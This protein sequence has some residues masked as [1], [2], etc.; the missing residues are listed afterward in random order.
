MQL[1]GL[2]ALSNDNRHLILHTAQTVLV[3]ILLEEERPAR[4][5]PALWTVIAHVYTAASFRKA[6]VDDSYPEGLAAGGVGVTWTSSK[7]QLS[8]L[9][10]TE[11]L[12]TVLLCMPVA[13][14]VS[15]VITFT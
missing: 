7:V 14:D 3:A 4:G 2:I 6:L 12:A 1:I 9:L 8:T 13:G 5:L 11:L 10:L 15:L